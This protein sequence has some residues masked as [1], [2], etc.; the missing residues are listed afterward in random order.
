MTKYLKKITAREI[1]EVAD[2][3][4][5]GG[6]VVFKTDT[7]YGIGANAYDEKACRRI[8]EIKQRPMRKPLSVLITDEEMLRKIV[9][10]IS[11]VEQK[12]MEGFWPGALTI[13]F[14][15]RPGVLPDVISAGDDFVR[16]RLL[17]EGVA[18]ELVAAAGVPVVAPSANLAGSPTG[19]K[20]MQIREELG[21]KVDY[22]LDEGDVADETTSTIVQVVDGKV[23]MIREG[24]IKQEEIER[25]LDKNGQVC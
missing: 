23:I 4:R 25:Y 13:K 9:E 12:L 22:V 16:V 7:V 15:K 11:P 1:Q 19:T 17:G 6:V 18:R 24:K 5:C 8:Y 10:T 2:A 21:E 20:M 14:R 3:I